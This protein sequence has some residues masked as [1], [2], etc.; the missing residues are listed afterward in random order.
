MT[1]EDL[2]NVEGLSLIAFKWWWFDLTSADRCYFSR[3]LVTPTF[4][5]IDIAL[6]TRQHPTMTEVHFDS[7]LLSS[8]KGKVA[9]IT[10]TPRLTEF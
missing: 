7:A 3:D 4:P 5:M 6:L 9:L 2:A 8:L 10:G 1:T